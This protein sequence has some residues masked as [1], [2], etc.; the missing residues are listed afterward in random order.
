MQVYL[1]F[2][3]LFSVSDA[4]IV[5]LCGETLLAHFTTITTLVLVTT[6]FCPIRISRV[7]AMWD[8]AVCWLI[9]AVGHPTVVSF[10]TA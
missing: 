3:H 8:E 1:S 9:G 2:G 4:L 6:S 10:L 5:L 7:A